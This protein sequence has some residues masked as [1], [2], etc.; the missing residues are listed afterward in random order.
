MIEPGLTNGFNRAVS[1]ATQH[2]F[3]GCGKKQKRRH[4]EESA[5]ADDEESLFLLDNR[6]RGIPHFVRNDAEA[7]FFRSLFN[8]AVKAARINT[9]SAAEVR[10]QPSGRRGG[11][12]LP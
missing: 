10:F 8:R 1:N 3:T 12:C 5:A 7:A 9:A 4:S 6:E 2:D 11:T